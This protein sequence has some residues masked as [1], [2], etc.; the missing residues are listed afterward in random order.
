MRYKIIISSIFLIVIFHF[1]VNGQIWEKII[2][3]NFES[4]GSAGNE[5]PSN[6]SSF[7][8]SS[9]TNAKWSVVKQG[10]PYPG[11]SFAFLEEW[12]TGTNYFLYCA[13]IDYKINIIKPYYPNDMETYFSNQFYWT[14]YPGL[15]GTN[16]I[17]L[18]FKYWIP[19]IGSNDEFY[20]T[21]EYA[22]TEKVIFSTNEPTSNG[23]YDFF[24]E[25]IAIIP[26]SIYR[27]IY[28]QL[29]VAIYFS[30]NF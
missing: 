29:Q 7:E 23:D 25:E 9:K 10:I 18:S 30:A 13:G 5:T 27:L 12:Y 3:E 4:T 26:K 24:N 14:D 19:D 20:V 2:D 21:V 8:T 6:W 16:K 15:R 11:A 17:R 1:S 28:K 22:N